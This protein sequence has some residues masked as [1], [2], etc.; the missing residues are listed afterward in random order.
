MASFLH[1]E[2]RIDAD[3]G[4]VHGGDVIAEVGALSDLLHESFVAR[5]NDGGNLLDPVLAQVVQLLGPRDA[6][7]DALLDGFGLRLLEVEL[8]QVVGAELG[9]LLE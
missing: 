4:V 3:L 1:P 6:V 5:R 7:G 9:L 8:Q 2:R